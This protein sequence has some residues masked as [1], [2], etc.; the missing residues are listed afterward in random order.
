MTK[1]GL[2]AAIEKVETS[3]AEVK[4]G[5]A[6]LSE[7]ENTKNYALITDATIKR[8]EVLFEYTWKLLK[9]AAEY[10]GIE[11][12]GPRPAIQEGVHLG[13]IQ[14]PEFWAL[15][16]DAR[17]ASI[18]DYLTKDFDDYR[19]IISRF[20]DEVEDLLSSLKKIGSGQL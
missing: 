19:N 9:I 20:A 10:Q 12:P 18:H 15:A 3:L 6:A 14:D 1:A 5:L 7:K 11:A 16:L 13:W 8:F 17:N 2:K 4:E